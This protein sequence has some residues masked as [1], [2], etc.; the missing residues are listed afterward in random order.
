[1]TPN[2]L[3]DAYF[4]LWGT[5]SDAERHALAEKIFAESAVHYSA[6]S[7]VSFSGVGEIEANIARI[8][9]ENIQQAG[10]G[11]RPGR[12]VPNHDSVHVEWE[13]VHPSGKTL[14][15]GRDF[16]LLD[17]DGKITTLYMFTGL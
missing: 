10:L 17:G 13:V 1:M 15:A 7:N 14:A 11:F 5:T 2:D 3:V 6:P 12:S 4:E 8:N 16:L 9:K